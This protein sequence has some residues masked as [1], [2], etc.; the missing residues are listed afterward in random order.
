MHFR[1]LRL[2]PLF[3]FSLLLAACVPMTSLPSEPATT[4]V[5]GPKQI[6]IAETFWPDAGYAIES[7]DAFVLTSWGAVEPLIR[8]NFAGEI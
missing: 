4:T 1:Q 2:L 7:D 6:T 3:L 8:I 5:D